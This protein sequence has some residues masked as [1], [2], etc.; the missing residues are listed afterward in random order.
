M[1]VCTRVYMYITW[2]ELEEKVL[3]AA[4]VQFHQHSDFVTQVV[5]NQQKQADLISQTLSKIDVHV[6]D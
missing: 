3:D 4:A 1:V 2:V 6:N 5:Q